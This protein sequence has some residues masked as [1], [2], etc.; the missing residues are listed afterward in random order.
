M[1]LLLFV[2]GQDEVLGELRR[3]T[4]RYGGG[5]WGMKWILCFGAVSLADI[6][7]PSGSLLY[8]SRG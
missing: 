3:L 5:G 1:R 7:L 2:A 4:V 8:A 6:P